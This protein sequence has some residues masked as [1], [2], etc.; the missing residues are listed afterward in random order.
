VVYYGRGEFG[1]NEATKKR[2]EDLRKQL[3]EHPAL[4]CSGCGTI[5]HEAITGKYE[6]D[7]GILCKLC[8]VKRVGNEIEKYPIKS[9]PL[10]RASK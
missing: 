8:F 3:R 5:I 10:E 4:R 9:A 2:I 7:H 1:V 6:T